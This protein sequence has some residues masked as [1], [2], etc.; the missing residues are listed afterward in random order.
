MASRSRV[1]PKPKG[2]L[3]VAIRPGRKPTGGARRK[4]RSGA[5]AFRVG[6]EVPADFPDICRYPIQGFIDHLAQHFSGAPMRVGSA[7]V[8]A[9]Q[10]EVSGELR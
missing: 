4:S 10:I 6:L 8:S 3:L 9:T 2:A 7:R 5:R 1:W